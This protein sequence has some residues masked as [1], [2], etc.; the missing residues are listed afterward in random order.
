MLRNCFHSRALLPQNSSAEQDLS[1][2]AISLM[3]DDLMKLTMP[4]EEEGCFL[5]SL[6]LSSLL[7]KIDQVAGKPLS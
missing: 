6:T 2:C 1:K 3:A 5:Q 4:E 7:E